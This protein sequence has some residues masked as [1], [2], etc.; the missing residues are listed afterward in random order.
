[1]P[2]PEAG[3]GGLVAMNRDIGPQDR[4]RD[5]LAIEVFMHDSRFK[6]A[7][8]VTCIGERRVGQKTDGKPL[9]RKA[10]HKFV[11]R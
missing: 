5:I 1:M 9:D 3:E 7:C 10:W 8:I 2:E 6:A 11:L 4:F